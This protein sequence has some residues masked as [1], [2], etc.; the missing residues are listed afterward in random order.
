MKGTTLAQPAA[1]IAA[2]PPQPRP[3]PPANSNFL[4]SKA[5][6]VRECSTFPKST[7]LRIVPAREPS[8]GERMPLKRNPLS[9]LWHWIAD[10][11]VQDVPANNELCEFD[12]RKGQCTAGEWEVCDRRLHKAAG[13]LMP[14]GQ[15]PG[16]EK[17]KTGPSDAEVTSAQN[18]AALVEASQH[19][20]KPQDPNPESVVAS[21]RP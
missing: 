7:S 15:Q 16:A 6:D 13:E 20:Q 12:C 1:S 10:Q 21:N 3:D 14:G 4:A 11:I 8:T 5:P 18:L 9:R 19:S 17:T 2:P